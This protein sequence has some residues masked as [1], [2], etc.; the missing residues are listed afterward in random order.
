MSQCTAKS[1]RS[2]ERCKAQAVRGRT[3]C[4]MHGGTHPVGA[5]APQYKHGRY[6]KVLPPKL[7][8]R[9]QDAQRDPELLALREEITVVDAMLAEAL[10]RIDETDSA[11]AWADAQKHYRA[12]ETARRAG[13]TH[14]M[15]IALVELGDVLERGAAGKGNREEVLKLIASRKALV[16][17]ER[18]RLVDMH[19]MVSSERA[20]AMMHALV[21]AVKEAVPDPAV[22]AKVN[23]TYTRLLNSPERT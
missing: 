20:L 11:E 9:Y 7:L 4:R 12:M 22:W 1:K 15:R 13:D 17:S 16:E 2:G 18:K 10:H 23:A 8:D 21:S 14:R 19:Q 3:T 5:L 6:S